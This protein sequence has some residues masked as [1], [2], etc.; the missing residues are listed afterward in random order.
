M[1]MNSWWLGGIFAIGGVAVAWFA[2]SRQTLY[3][4]VANSVPVAVA[5]AKDAFGNRLTSERTPAPIGEVIEVI[6]LSQVFEPK[7][8]HDYLP[9]IEF[10]PDVFNRLPPPAA[11]SD[12]PYAAEELPFPRVVAGT[13]TPRYG[14]ETSEPPAQRPTGGT[15]FADW[16]CGSCLKWVYQMMPLK[17]SSVPS[18]ME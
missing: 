12:M 5:S 13:A 16:L 8:D 18:D 10:G 14:E 15:S 1:K 2:G 11:P 6:D 4:P 3:S 9:I 7:P 17:G